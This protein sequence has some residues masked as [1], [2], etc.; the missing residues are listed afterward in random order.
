M[1]TQTYPLRPEIPCEST[2]WI[3]WNACERVM[4]FLLTLALFP[5][6]A[7][8]AAA[9]FMLSRRAPLVAHARAGQHGSPLFVWKFRTMWPRAPSQSTPGWIEYLPPEDR[10]GEE[11]KRAAD[12]RVTSRFAHWCRRYSIDEL[13][14]LVHV[15]RGD[16]S[17]VGPRPLTFAE[18]SRHYGDAAH[19]ILWARPGITGLWQVSGRGRLSYAERRELDLEFV[20]RRSLGM[21]V[22]ILAR[23][24]PL[25]LTGRDAW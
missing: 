24:I 25:V 15:I 14:Q 2:G 5:L 11:P 17:L 6:L 22:R 16:M 8:C 7:G 20:R 19:E 10:A 13:P 18:L 1:S 3:V 12:P 4:A 9:I 21:Y 23:T